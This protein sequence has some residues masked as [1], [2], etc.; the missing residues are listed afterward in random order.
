MYRVFC[1]FDEGKIVVLFNAYQKKAQKTDRHK[2]KFA[3]KLKNEYFKT[4][5]N[6][7]GND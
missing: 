7:N 4:K 2:I 6:E 3:E 1:C 5:D